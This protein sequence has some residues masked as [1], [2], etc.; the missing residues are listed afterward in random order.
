[1]SINPKARKEHKIAHKFYKDCAGFSLFLLTYL[2]VI[3]QLAGVYITPISENSFQRLN[4]NIFYFTTFLAVVCHIRAS[5]EDPGLITTLNNPA[6]IYMYIKN[7]AKSIMVSH[8]L[9]K[10]L[11]K[12]FEKDKDKDNENENISSEDETDYIQETSVTD[13]IANKLMKDYNLI[14]N[15]CSKCYVVKLPKTQHCN[16][17]KG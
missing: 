7:N 1:M 4:N 10:Q 17:C 13:E 11:G 9:N 3:L 6:N 8:E 14:V 12:E 15:R 16:K 5:F 2:C